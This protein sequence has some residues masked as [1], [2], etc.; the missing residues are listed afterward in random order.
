MPAQRLVEAI[1]AVSKKRGEV[2]AGGGGLS[3]VVDGKNLP[4]HPWSGAAP[5]FSKQ[6]PVMV[7]STKD[8]LTYQLVMHPDF[9][10]LDEAGLRRKLAAQL[11]SRPDRFGAISP[12]QIEGIIDVYRRG[13]PDERPQDLLVAMASDGTRLASIRLAEAR[14]RQANAAPV[15]MY[16]FE[17]ESPALN[18]TL[19]STHT[20]EIPFVFDNLKVSDEYV[21][22]R[23][24][25][26]QLMAQISDAWI[27]FAR[28]GSPNH[29][30]LPR[31]PAYDDADA[32]HDDLRRRESGAERPPRRRARGV[33]RSNLGATWAHSHVT[34]STGRVS[35]SRTTVGAGRRSSSRTDSWTR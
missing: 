18:G 3:P 14:A 24:E 5:E 10:G 33:G 21:G 7:G 31:W 32:R 6:V 35:T 19:K 17:W 22:P 4:G 34:Q 2:G 30:G 15:Y 20:L 12:E 9:D 8:E 26:E 16:L 13:R 25:R 23:P 28:T 29:E 11:G 1:G 27:A